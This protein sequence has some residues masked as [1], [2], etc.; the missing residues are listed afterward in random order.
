M[1]VSSAL[2][3]FFV[4]VVFLA[5]EMMMPAFILIFFTAGCWIAGISAWLFD[6]DLTSQLAVFIFSSLVLLIS[7]R[8]YGLRTFKGRVAKE[9]EGLS[10]D[11]KIGKTALVTESIHPGREGEIKMQGSFW[12][13]V[14]D[15]EIPEGR[16]VLVVEKTTEGGLTFRVKELEGK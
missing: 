12:R 15:T 3:W 16:S 7:L 2:V 8:K 5:A 4:G 1:I 6:L 13:A 9:V 14:A 10:A 11:A